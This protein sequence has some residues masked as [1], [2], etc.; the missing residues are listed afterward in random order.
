MAAKK[1]PAT[2]AVEALPYTGNTDAEGKT[3]AHPAARKLMAILVNNQF[4]NLG[5]YANRPM[6]GSTRLSVHATG[7]ALDAGYKQSRQDWVT[8]FCDWLAEHHRELLIEEIH[9]Y[10]WGT[11]GR[12]FRCNRNGKPGWLTWDA[13]NNGGPGGY[14]LHLEVAPNQ[15]ADGI[16]QAWKRIPPF[17]G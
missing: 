16:V 12:G 5:I 9:Q 1:K 6:R 14:W 7:R 11:H 10:V 15:T 3:A 4:Q 13:E 8:G 2:P 17:T